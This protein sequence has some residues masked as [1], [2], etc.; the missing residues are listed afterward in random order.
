MVFATMASM[1]AATGAQ[2]Q[3][4]VTLLGYYTAGDGGGGSFYWDTSSS[5]IGND[6]TIVQAPGGF[7]V[8]LADEPASVK[9]F[10][11]KDDAQSPNLTDNTQRLQKCLDNCNSI[12]FDTG[13]Y[14]VNNTLN[15]KSGRYI[16]LN[17]S[18]LT[19]VNDVIGT[20]MF[21]IQQQTKI[22]ITNGLL[23][24][25]R[26]NQGTKDEEDASVG[27]Y[28][29]G[30]P[31]AIKS[32]IPANA[33]ASDI[34][35]DRINMLY[36]LKGI[37]L[38][39]ATRRIN[40]LN[41]S[42]YCQNGV[43]YRGKTVENVIDGSV[44]YC[45]RSLSGCFGIGLFGRPEEQVFY[46]EGLTITNCTIDTFYNSFHVENIYTLQV[47]NNYLGANTVNGNATFYFTKGVASHC[48]DILI[49]N[50]MIY[51][52]GIIFTPNTA[53]PQLYH[54]SIANC[55]FTS[56]TG[57]SITLNNFAGNVA[58]RGCQFKA[59]NTTT[60][61]VAIVANN[62]NLYLAIS[63][64]QIDNTYVIPIQVKGTGSNN[65]SVSNVSFRGTGDL[66]YLEQPVLLNNNSYGTASDIAYV[67]KYQPITGTYTPGQKITGI[68][69]RF[70]KGEKGFIVLNGYCTL[71]TN[72]SILYVGVPTGVTLA[73]GPGWASN[74]IMLHN[75]QHVS[76]SIPYVALAD[77]TG[78][79]ELTNFN[80]NTG[81]V[82]IDYHAY[83]GVM[84]A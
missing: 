25:Y 77:V 27:I 35:I 80:E 16:D 8:R 79:I 48:Q 22:T 72:K 52:R 41:S 50:N 54:A 83:F 19:L 3:E 21:R 15:I 74:F 26:K 13:A 10:G 53:A 43:E 7:W 30:D 11:V 60:T 14:S 51:G 63:D 24:G 39:H 17:G 5:L 49:E 82:A 36:F 9:W 62:N 78:E 12:L 76:F 1:K 47:C 68:S 18:V 65:S 31:N 28:I 67:Y 20:I 2:P 69:K 66:L 75:N 55:I 71:A 29:V 23:I 81:T 59:A 61:N 64:I 57:T 37:V 46:P 58:I 34:V 45:S 56:Q 38:L 70:A 32:P 42:L 73:A 84:Q 6:G 44:I 33:Y 4:V 40:I